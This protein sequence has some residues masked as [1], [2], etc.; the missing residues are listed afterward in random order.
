MAT[1]NYKKNIRQ[2]RSDLARLKKAGLVSP[3]IDARSHKPTRHMLAQLAKY[4][5]V[6]SGDAVTVKAP[7]RSKASEYSDIKRVKFDRVV[8]KT[9][10][11]DSKPRYNRR[12]DEIEI[13]RKSYFPGVE[14]YTQ[15]LRSQHA[16]ELPVLPRDTF[17]AV[18]KYGMP[19]RRGKTI[20]RIFADSLSELMVLMSPYDPA[21]GGRFKD[22]QKYIEIIKVNREDLPEDEFEISRD[23]EDEEAGKRAFN[24]R[25]KA[26]SQAR[27]SKGRFVKTGRGSAS[28]KKRPKT[29][30]K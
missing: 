16:D 29:T 13:D 20:R 6:I 15:L 12:T 5:D 1:K 22:W 2:Y 18:Y 21:E 24:K 30:R 9:A 3:K 23:F 8:I 19:F 4:A 26:A 14:A 11:G 10:P 25:R 7:S 28:T 17:D 27:D